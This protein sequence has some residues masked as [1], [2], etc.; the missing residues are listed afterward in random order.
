MI[1]SWQAII[2]LYSFGYSMQSIQISF[3]FD[4][5]AKQGDISEQGSESD[6]LKNKLMEIQPVT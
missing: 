6:E 4:F 1:L 5:D 2:G 3:I